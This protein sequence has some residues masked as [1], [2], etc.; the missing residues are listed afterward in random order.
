[1]LLH[2]KKT[3]VVA[4]GLAT[5][6]HAVLALTPCCV[7]L[8]TQFGVHKNDLYGDINIVNGEAWPVLRQEP[9]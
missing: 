3:E 4:A 7:E 9:K 8:L 5:S 2:T 1:V 6:M